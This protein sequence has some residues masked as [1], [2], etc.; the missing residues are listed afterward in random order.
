MLLA[1]IKTIPLYLFSGKMFVFDAYLQCRNYGMYARESHQGFLASDYV[2]NDYA[3]MFCFSSVPLLNHSAC[4]E[5]S[6]TNLVHLKCM[7]ASVFRKLFL[8]A[9][10]TAA[11]ALQGS[12]QK[13]S[14]RSLFSAYAP[15]DNSPIDSY[16]FFSVL[17]HASNPAE[18]LSHLGKIVICSGKSFRL[19]HRVAMPRFRSLFSVTLL[20]S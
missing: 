14:L 6:M 7:V 8:R 12:Y 19:R 10:E 20:K 5:F 17:S 1:D 16:F 2:H 3:A 11:L 4:V 15:L 13:P 18:C 9:A